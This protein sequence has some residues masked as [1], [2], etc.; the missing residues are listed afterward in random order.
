M[1]RIWTGLNKMPYSPRI[2]VFK[3]VCLKQREVIR[4]AASNHMRALLPGALPA[5]RVCRGSLRQKRSEKRP[6]SL[7]QLAQGHDT[8]ESDGRTSSELNLHRS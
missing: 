2:V 5:A 8:R 1:C 3:L 4:C 6:D 7:S